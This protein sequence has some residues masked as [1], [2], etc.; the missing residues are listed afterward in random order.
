MVPSVDAKRKA[1]VKKQ[2]TRRKVQ[3]PNAVTEAEP[4]ANPDGG[5]S[6]ISTRTWSRSKIPRRRIR[7]ANPAISL[8]PSEDGELVEVEVPDDALRVNDEEDT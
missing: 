7:L 1:K 2:K 5:K 4:I 6:W 3:P 8:F